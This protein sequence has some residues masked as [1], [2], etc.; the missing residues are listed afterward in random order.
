MDRMSELFGEGRSVTKPVNFFCSAPAATSVYLVGDFNNWS[1][2][3]NPMSRRVEGWWYL[4]VAL[5]HGHH[6]YRFLVDGRPRLD[7]R[8]AGTAVDA[9]QGEV[10]LVPVS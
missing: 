4:Q 7:P 1:P 10:S 5:T 2:T 3:A 9:V 6:R 8:S